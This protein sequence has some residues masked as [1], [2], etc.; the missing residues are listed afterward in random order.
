MSQSTEPLVRSGL[1]LPLPDEHHSHLSCC[2]LRSAPVGPP[3][4]AGQAVAVLCYLELLLP[5]SPPPFLLDSHCPER[6][7]RTVRRRPERR[8]HVRSGSA[9]QAAVVRVVRAP[10]GSAVVVSRPRELRRR[11]RDR[12][13][14]RSTCGR[15]TSCFFASAASAAAAAVNILLEKTVKGERGADGGARIL[16]RLA[17]VV[18][19][20]V[21]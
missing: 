2:P 15:A 19:C 16:V 20:M 14:E 12:V 10:T 8:S 18:S 13:R 21:N 11:T 6:F 5:Q 17:F 9:Q 4:A 7:V 1:T 3:A